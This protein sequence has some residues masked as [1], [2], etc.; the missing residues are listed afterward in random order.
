MLLLR[1]LELPRKVDQSSQAGCA[2]GVGR[3]RSRS[4]HLHYL[5]L[6]TESKE[7]GLHVHQKLEMRVRV[8]QMTVMAVERI[9]NM[10]S[11]TLMVSHDPIH[12]KVREEI[13]DGVMWIVSAS[14]TM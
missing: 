7:V 8:I 4:S 5:Y 14:A 12:P 6:E 1:G 10:I 2:L 3:A 9:Q 11:G 13:P